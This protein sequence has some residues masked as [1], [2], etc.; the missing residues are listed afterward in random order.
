[1]TKPNITAKLRAEMD[2]ENIAIMNRLDA[3]IAESKYQREL[4]RWLYVPKHNTRNPAR[5]DHYNLM[6]HT[7]KILKI[8]KGES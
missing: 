3:V 4:R 2:E 8:A 6:T 5:Y 7:L 1:M